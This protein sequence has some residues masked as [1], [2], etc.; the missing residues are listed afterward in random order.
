MHF[1]L[2]STDDFSTSSSSSSNTVNHA[3]SNDG[4]LTLPNELKIA[5]YHHSGDPNTLRLNGTVYRLNEGRVFLIDHTASIE[6]IEMTPSPVRDKEELHEFTESLWNY[7]L[8]HAVPFE[9]KQRISGLQWQ[10]GGD[11]Q[12]VTWA[13][14]GRLMNNLE[15]LTWLETLD[16]PVGQDPGPYDEGF[17]YQV[18]KLAIDH[19]A[20]DP[21]TSLTCN[22]YDKEGQSLSHG[23]QGRPPYETT[24]RFSADLKIP[25]PMLNTISLKLTASGGQ[26]QRRP[27]R[28]TEETFNKRIHFLEFDNFTLNDPGGQEFTIDV[29]VIESTEAHQLKIVPILHTGERVDHRSGRQRSGRVDSYS[30]KGVPIEEIQAFEFYTRP[31]REFTYPDLPLMPYPKSNG[32]R[33][34]RE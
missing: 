7:D 5:F 8:N 23:S 30:F 14:D 24:Y 1:I 13:R 29:Q 25:P 2:H 26:W 21:S 27:E 3:W 34:Y 31:L 28:L 11:E 16:F 10:V 4:T 6:Q 15:D 9:G 32:I 18:L 19:P 17:D 12:P 33:G 22:F 20:F